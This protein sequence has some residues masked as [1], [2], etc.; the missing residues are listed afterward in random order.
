MKRL[1]APP[2]PA[3]VAPFEEDHDALAALLH[4]GLQLEQL[5]LQQ[6]LLLL[7]GLAGHEVLVRVAAAPPVLGELFVGFDEALAQARIGRALQRAAQ[8]GGGRQERHPRG[9]RAGVWPARRRQCHCRAQECPAPRRAWRLARRPRLRGSPRA[10]C[11]SARARAAHRLRQ[12]GV[13]GGLA[14]AEFSRW[15]TNGGGGAWHGSTSARLCKGVAI[16]PLCTRAWQVF[17][18]WRKPYPPPHVLPGGPP[19]RAMPPSRAPGGLTATAAGAGQRHRPTE[20]GYRLRAAQWS[21]VSPAATAATLS[22]SARGSMPKPSPHAHRLPSVRI[23]TE[24][25]EPVAMVRAPSNHAAPAVGLVAQ[26]V[27]PQRPEAV[28]TGAHDRAAGGSG[29]GR[30]RCAPSRPPRLARC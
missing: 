20:A 28:A 11:S 18:T 27:R 1:I 21:P 14:R 3:R 23:A 22:I 15:G 8:H 17:L 5:D 16:G 2:L 19:R 26:P 6:V 10:E 12:R 24:W 9:W 25:R 7:V 4:P 29:R 30:V 13:P